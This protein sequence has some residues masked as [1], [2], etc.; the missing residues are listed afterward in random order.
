MCPYKVIFFFYKNYL[1]N[2]LLDYRYHKYKKTPM[3]SH[4]APIKVTGLVKTS[5]STA[6]LTTSVNV[7]IYFTLTEVTGLVEKSW[8]TGGLTTSLNIL[9][10][11]SN[12]SDRISRDILVYQCTDFRLPPPPSRLPPYNDGYLQS[13][14]FIFYQFS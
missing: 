11:Y 5:W 4:F 13:S 14:I 12:W 6:S 3:Y 7:F 2:Y 1:A 8:S 10:F 9:S